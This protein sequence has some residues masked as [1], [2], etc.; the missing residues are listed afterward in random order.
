MILKKIGRRL[1]NDDKEHPNFSSWA[2]TYDGGHR[3]GIM[4]SNDSE[5][6]NSIFI[7]ERTLSVTA[8]MK[9]TW[10]KCAKWFDKREIE[11]LNLHRA[12]K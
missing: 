11:V 10:Y 12:C 3:W 8:I 5:A 7:F 1:E 2:Q 6:L 4:T 9:G